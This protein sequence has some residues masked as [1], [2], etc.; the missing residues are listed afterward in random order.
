[1]KGVPQLGEN[2]DALEK[3]TEA[4]N[5]PKRQIRAVRQAVDFLMGDAIGLGFGS[6]LWRQGRLSSESGEF[7]PLY[8][9][10]SSNFR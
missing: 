2:L 6:V 1:M 4:L 8:E 7:Y 10:R 3:L 9:G 5:P